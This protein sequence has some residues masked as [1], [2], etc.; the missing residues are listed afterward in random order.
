MV[1]QST[2]QTP[3][4]T[5]QSG[6]KT[7]EDPPVARALF[8]STAW[9]WLWLLLRL[10]VGWEWLNAGWGKIQS[11]AWTGS[12]AGTA[13]SGFINGALGKTAGDHPD[14]QV[15][16]A[17]FL[18]HLVLPYAGVWSYL[19]A[20]GE[21][22]VGVALILGLFTGLAAFF[23]SFMNANYLMAGT[24]STNP[25][26]FIIATWLVLAWKT[27]GW[28]GLDRWLLP[29][30]GTPWRPGFIFHGQPDRP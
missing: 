12:Q 10:Y 4:H 14:V 5:T 24:V 17:W 6:V 8:G 25:L 27:A 21:L 26:L 30:L 28:W 15:W 20:W 16:Y 19:V 22:L 1:D 13:L 23:G 18:Q 7:I 9:A 3:V 2:R 11:P 29:A